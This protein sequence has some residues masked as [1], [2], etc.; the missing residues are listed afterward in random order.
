MTFPSDIQACM[1]DCILAVMWSKDDIYSFF[2]NHCTQSDLK[3]LDNYK[4]KLTRVAMIDRVFDHL[5]SSVDGGLGSFRAM[6]KSLEEWSYF[7]PYYFDTLKKL[8]RNKAKN[9]IDHLRQLRE[10]RDARMQAQRERQE[11]IKRSQQEARQTIEAL[12]KSFLDL[13]SGKIPVQK[14]GYELEKI[15][16]ELGRLSG[17]E[18]TEPFRVNGEQIDGTVKYDGEHYLIEAKWQD[19]A[20]SNEPV[21]QFVGKVEGRMYG[22]GIFVS[23]H[24]FSDYVVRS[25]AI[26]K[27]IKTFFVDGE[28][29]VCVLEERLSF[30]QLIDRKV[31]AAQTRGEIY[32][33]PL[34][35]TSKVT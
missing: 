4:D 15:L 30:S 35:E 22:R 13:H 20:A 3:V 11:E 21:Y 1:R 9:T 14:R 17:L 19:Q 2:K 32:I 31:K 29:L 7:D 26:G 33:H 34:S 8:D 5:A 25:I 27:A 24:G 6:L 12:K 10:I 18:V 28:D 23:V 16:L